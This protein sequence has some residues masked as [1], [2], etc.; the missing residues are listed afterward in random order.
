[1]LDV[2]EYVIFNTKATPAIFYL[3][4]VNFFSMWLFVGLSIADYVTGSKIDI[5]VS[6]VCNNSTR[7]CGQ[8]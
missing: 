8:H 4:Q 6:H 5:N 1:M 7:V 3:N 2:L